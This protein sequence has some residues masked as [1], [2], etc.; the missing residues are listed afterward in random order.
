MLFYAAIGQN[1]TYV[2]VHSFRL[3]EKSKMNMYKLKTIFQSLVLALILAFDFTCPVFSQVLMSS[4]TESELSNKI[5]PPQGVIE[6]VIQSEPDDANILKECMLNDG[7]GKISMVEFFSAQAIRLK[8]DGLQD[9]F[10][11]PALE[12]Y[13]SAF[14]G[15][16]L[17]RYWFVVS[18][19]KE[20]KIAYRVIFKSGGD[21]VRVLEH[22]TNGYH[23]LELVGRNAVKAETSTWRFD[24]K[25]YVVSGCFI[26]DVNPEDARTSPC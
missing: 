4:E 22:V 8:N 9:Y 6:L 18:Y 16:H 17:F 10:V 15:A 25:K 1:R 12:P 19:R 3:F 21:K 26:R 2:K 20:G 24:G 5:K 13:C 23:D 14:Y 7:Q 11:R